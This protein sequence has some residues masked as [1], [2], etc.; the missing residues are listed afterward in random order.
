[1]MAAIAVHL[2]QTLLKLDWIA[3][4]TQNHSNGHSTGPHT[5]SQLDANQTTKPLVVDT[6]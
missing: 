5:C 2:S 6:N 4:A 1:M 3:R